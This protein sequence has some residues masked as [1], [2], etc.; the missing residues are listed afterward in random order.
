MDLELAG[1]TG[2]VLAGSQGLG[3]AIAEAWAAE[4]VSVAIVARSREALD[5]V[6]LSIH[7]RGGAALCLVADL[8]DPSSLE[9]AVNEA[10]AELGGIDLV[11]LNTGGPALT[12]PTG[13]SVDVWEGQFHSLVAPLVRVVEM[14]VPDMRAKGWGRILYIA[15][16]GVIAPMAYTTVSQSMRVAVASWLKTLAAE[17]APD[18]VTVN[19][20][21]PGIIK[22]DRMFSLLEK[23][24]QMDGAPM[25]QHLAN[26]VA[27]VPMGRMGTPREFAAVAAF[28]ASPLAA[29]VTGSILKV[30][31]GWIRAL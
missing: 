28:L 13:A 17:V 7:E 6:N 29:Y 24:A 27:D 9:A 30:D 15:A 22:T 10:K 23:R 11:L 14:L 21:I 5:A 20:I 16:P 19:T 31:G 8:D 12:G 2:L 3:R 18:G 26:M 4:G 1:K 25:E